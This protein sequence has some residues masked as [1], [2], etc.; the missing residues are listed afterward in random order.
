MKANYLVIVVAGIAALAYANSDPVR[1]DFEIGAVGAKPP[2]WTVAKTGEGQGSVWKIVSD[3]T[4]PLGAKVLAQTAESPN[5]MYNLCVRDTAK[6]QDVTVSVA[7]K[8]V[9][10]KL[11]QGGGLVWRYTDRDN[12]YVCR[13]NPLEDNFR[14]YKVVG[15][16]RSQLA[17]KEEVKI[18]DRTWHTLSVTMVGD[19]IECS[20]DGKKHLEAKDA[21]FAQPGLVGLWTKADAQTYFDDFR[22]QDA[23]K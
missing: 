3:P 17:T 2:H 10:G 5:A 9:A 6:F 14:V 16:K 21:T 23:V 12:Y 13:M 15:G 8:A 18:P 22:A 19:A 4:A 7:F 20:L 1:D 11:D